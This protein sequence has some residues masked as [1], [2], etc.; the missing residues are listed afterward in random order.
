MATDA[1]D[2]VRALLE[3]HG[4]TYAERAGVTVRDQPAALFQLLVMSMLMS[5]RISSGIAVDAANALW[6]AGW[7]TPDKMAASTWRQ[8][9]DVLNRAGYAR[10][11]ERTSRMLGEVVELLQERY[12]GDLRK[13]RQKADGDLERMRELL[14]EF[15]GIGD[16]GADIF[17]REVQVAWPEVHPFVDGRV[18]RLAGKLDLP[19]QADKLAGLVGRDDFPRML[20]ALVQADHQDDIEA[21][22]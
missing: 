9:T 17:L 2:T 22:R 14:T 16:V 13:M 15:K 5:A 1:K 4:E 3:R 6:D 21:L 11:D 8:R 19:K 7:T 20:D 12:H 10:Y 18:E